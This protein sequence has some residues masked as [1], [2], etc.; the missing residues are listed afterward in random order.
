MNIC[1]FP[2]MNCIN[3]AI[4]I[5]LFQEIKFRTKLDVPSLNSEAGVAYETTSKNPKK[6]QDILECARDLE[7]PPEAMNSHPSQLLGRQP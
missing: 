5:G 6:A 7:L 2:S 4:N 1:N 3:D